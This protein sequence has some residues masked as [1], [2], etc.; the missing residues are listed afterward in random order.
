MSHDGYFYILGRADDVIKVAGKRVGPNEV[1]DTVL[2]VHGVREAACIGIP[3]D[4]K[5]EGLV[6]FYMGD[7]SEDVSNAV[8]QEIEKSLGKSFS[9]K[10][11]I[12]VSSLPRTRSGKIMRR[13]VRSAYL[14]L[15]S[16][17]TNNLENPE[18]LEE[19]AAIGKGD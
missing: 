12:W 14:H 18:S 17:D 3:D 6:V 1:E 19:I 2:R 15:P 7:K 11:V 4:I 8:K 16:G 9:P 13:L 5:G 10:G